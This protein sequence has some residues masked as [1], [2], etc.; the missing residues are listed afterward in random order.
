MYHPQKCDKSLS[1]IF[2][3]ELNES[4]KVDDKDLENMFKD[5]INF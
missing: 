5:G 2:K 4:E 3:H 1:S